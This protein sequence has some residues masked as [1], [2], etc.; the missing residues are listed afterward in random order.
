MKEHGSDIWAFR[1]GSKRTDC[2]VRLK[3]IWPICVDHG[4]EVFH[5]FNVRQSELAGPDR[6][7]ATDPPTDLFEI[8]IW[9]WVHADLRWWGGYLG[10]ASDFG[11]PVSLPVSLPKLLPRSLHPKPF[12]LVRGP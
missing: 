10:G 2:V 6:V 11:V 8:E 5:G 3:W 7:V 9:V 4:D 12:V 1:A